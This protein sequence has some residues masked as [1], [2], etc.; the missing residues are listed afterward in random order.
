MAFSP[1]I[2]LNGSFHCL[3]DCIVFA[4][5]SAIIQAIFPVWNVFFFPGCFQDFLKNLTFDKFDYVVS[6]HGL[7]EFML[8]EIH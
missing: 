3:L 6:E 2:T 4:E 5:N 7:F 8:F 1:L